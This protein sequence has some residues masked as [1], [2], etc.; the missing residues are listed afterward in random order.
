MVVNLD[1]WRRLPA[2]TRTTIQDLAKRLEPEFW[3]VSKGEH[4]TRSAELQRNGMT[5]EEPPA[6]LVQALRQA[7]ATMADDF[8]RANAAA[9][10]ILQQFR[11]RV[12]R[13]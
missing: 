8:A 9:G 5:V 2:A 6:A 11:Q 12:G 10:P 1:A 3:N 4:A 13:A 7:T